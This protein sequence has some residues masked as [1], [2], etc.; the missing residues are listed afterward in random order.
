MLDQRRAGLTLLLCGTEGNTRTVVEATEA[1]APP[2]S[3]ILRLQTRAELPALARL[4]PERLTQLPVI[5]TSAPLSR[6]GMMASMP[7]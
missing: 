5:T 7:R 4:T 6:P 1:L 2:T 3:P